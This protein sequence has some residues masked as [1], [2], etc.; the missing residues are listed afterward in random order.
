M[1]S[2]FPGMDPYLEHPSL[3]PDVHHS[4]I[5]AIRDAMYYP[6]IVRQPI[7]AFSLPLYPDDQLPPVP[8]N[9]VLHDLYPRVRFDLRLDC[10]Q[11]PVPPISDED[12]GWAQVVIGTALQ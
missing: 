3:W 2:L 1:N 9:D 5:A 12:G 6:F 8:L 4:L 10:T 11:T 7:P